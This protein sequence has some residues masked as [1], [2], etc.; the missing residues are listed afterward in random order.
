MEKKEYI[1][2]IHKNIYFVLHVFGEHSTNNEEIKGKVAVQ[3]F[4]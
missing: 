3:L 1:V 2:I 4:Q